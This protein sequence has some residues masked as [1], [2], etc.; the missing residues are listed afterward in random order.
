MEPGTNLHFIHIC[1]HVSPCEIEYFL[2]FFA[3]ILLFCDRAQN[4][5]GGSVTLLSCRGCSIPSDHIS[6]PCVYSCLIVNVL[7][8]YI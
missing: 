5:K 8:I 2:I 6:L 7:Y 1:L 3:R 4:P